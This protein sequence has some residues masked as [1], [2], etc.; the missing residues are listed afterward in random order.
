MMPSK[1]SNP[2]SESPVLA[3]RKLTES[4]WFWACTFASVAA[5]ALIAIDGKYRRREAQLEGKAQMRLHLGKMN[6]EGVSARDAQFEQDSGLLKT[7]APL[8]WV[9]GGVVAVAWGM[10]FRA[11]AREV[12][13]GT[14]DRAA[15]GT[16]K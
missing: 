13:H 3:R 14:G 4:P 10:L 12:T 16:E 1:P 15:S 7:P 5:L 8:L 2:H 11:R 6:A 9:L